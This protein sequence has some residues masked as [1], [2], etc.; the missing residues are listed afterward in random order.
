MGTAI[1]RRRL[2]GNLPGRKRRCRGLVRDAQPFE[3]SIEVHRCEESNAK[4]GRAGK[5]GVQK[6]KRKEEISSEKDEL[7][8]ASGRRSGC[9]ERVL[10]MCVLTLHKPYAWVKTDKARRVFQVCLTRLGMLSKILGSALELS[11]L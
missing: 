2:G 11:R 4:S 8:V 9:G 10:Q 6:S 5:V 3:R 1:G 7:I